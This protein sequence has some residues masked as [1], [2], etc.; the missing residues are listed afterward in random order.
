MQNSAPPCC[1]RN[2]FLYP[3]GN[4]EVSINSGD[5]LLN[6][7]II[8]IFQKYLSQRGKRGSSPTQRVFLDPPPQAF[9]TVTAVTPA[10]LHIAAGC[11]CVDCTIPKFPLSA[12]RCPSACSTFSVV[13]M[14]LGYFTT[15]AEQPLLED[16]PWSWGSCGLAV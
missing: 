8:H 16:K 9:C 11:G 6:S 15:A 12:Q 7:Q 2:N 14:T 5:L 13:L 10:L 4:L 1:F 3:L